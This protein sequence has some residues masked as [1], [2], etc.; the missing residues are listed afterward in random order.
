MF[1]LVVDDF[2]VKYGG[3][4]HTKNLLNILIKNYE[5]VHEDWEGTKFCGITLK[6]DYA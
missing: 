6:W 2:G 3:D 5:G 4:E 1:A